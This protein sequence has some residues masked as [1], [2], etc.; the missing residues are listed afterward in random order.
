MNT[1]TAYL[2]IRLDHPPS[3]WQLYTFDLRRHRVVLTKIGREWKKRSAW[4]AVAAGVREPIVGP[5][6]VEINVYPKARILDIDNALKAAL[7]ALTGL[8]YGDDSQVAELHVYRHDPS[9]DPHLEV[10]VAH[11]TV[12][13]THIR[14]AQ[15]QEHITAGA[16]VEAL[17]N[18]G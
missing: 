3:L 14:R 8:A 7:D 2:N 9:A 18:Q 4:A 13:G 16:I 5:V 1:P 12:A 10:T 15:N 17:E 11:H 6:A